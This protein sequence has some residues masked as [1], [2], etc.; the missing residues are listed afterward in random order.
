MSDP[1]KPVSATMSVNALSKQFGHDRRTIDKLVAHIQPA[2]VEG[3]TKFYRLVDVEAALTEKGEDAPLREQKLK[4]EIRKLR[5]ANDAKEGKSELRSVTVA[6]IQKIGHEVRTY[7]GN[8]SKEKPAVIAMTTED[9]PRVR[10]EVQK[11]CDEIVKKLQSFA[12]HWGVK[13]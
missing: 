7:L 8:V 1:K 5:I 9:I 2:K 4:E 10:I 11:M 13:I 6:K 3:K 12:E